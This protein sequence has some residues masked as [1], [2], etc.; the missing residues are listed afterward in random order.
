MKRMLC[1]T[2]ALGIVT[3]G[4]ASAQDAATGSAHAKKTLADQRAAKARR[5]AIQDLRARGSN[6]PAAFSGAP[7]SRR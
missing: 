5:Q 4:M 3:T 6:I 2:F 7:E 1:L